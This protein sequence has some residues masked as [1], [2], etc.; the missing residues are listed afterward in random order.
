M[1]VFLFV[2]KIKDR[3]GILLFENRIDQFRQAGALLPEECS[4]FYFKL[5]YATYYLDFPEDFLRVME[6]VG[7][8]Y[9][10]FESGDNEEYLMACL[11]WA[12]LGLL[13]N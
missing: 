13:K 4:R 12:E 10:P 9:D 8:G 7:E 1:S 3:D 6:K 2:H 11:L 5:M